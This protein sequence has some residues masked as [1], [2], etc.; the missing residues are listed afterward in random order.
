MIPSP[1]LRFCLFVSDSAFGK[2]ISS[3]KECVQRKTFVAHLEG[4][5]VVAGTRVQAGR[6]SD[7]LRQTRSERASRGIGA[8]WAPPSRAEPSVSYAVIRLGIGGGSIGSNSTF[9]PDRSGSSDRT[10]SLCL[11]GTNA[12]ML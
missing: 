9:S 7:A 4:L 6:D 2:A 12:R 5:D 3:H 1:Y 10:R 11:S 8:N